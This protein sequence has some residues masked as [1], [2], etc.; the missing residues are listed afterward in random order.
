MLADNA[1]SQFLIGAQDEKQEGASL[2]QLRSPRTRY[3]DG[4]A[5]GSGERWEKGREG[6]VESMEGKKKRMDD[7]G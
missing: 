7:D 4:D 1:G 3:G 2:P 5:V 6:M